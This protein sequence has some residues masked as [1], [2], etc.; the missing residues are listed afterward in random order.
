MARLPRRHGRRGPSDAAE[1]RL[2]M[3]VRRPRA[4][5]VPARRLPPEGGSG[6]RC[7]A[8][9]R[10]EAAG[11]QRAR[12]GRWELTD[13]GRRRGVRGR[14]GRRR[15]RAEATTAGRRR[16]QPRE[17]AVAAAG[18]EQRT[19]ESSPVLSGGMDV[20]LAGGGGG[21][22]TPA[23]AWALQPPWVRVRG[24]SAAAGGWADRFFCQ[25]SGRRIGEWRKKG[26]AAGARPGAASG[27]GGG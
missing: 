12:P 8:A 6:E 17:R 25:P 16:G 3:A 4:R 26:R 14:R 11:P 10:C 13:G 20:G 1:Q 5:R 23:V 24:S 21:D 22:A 2:A 15:R 9:E 27:G 19:V 18:G 7:S